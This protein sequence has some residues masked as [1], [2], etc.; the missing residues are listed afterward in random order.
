MAGMSGFL[1]LADCPRGSWTSERL[2]GQSFDRRGR[3]MAML[4]LHLD[5]AIL[6]EYSLK[7]SSSTPLP[8]PRGL[9]LWRQMATNRV[10]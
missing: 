1:R 5:F 9:C 6:E 3:Q 4:S 7:S 2:G 8:D 10:Q